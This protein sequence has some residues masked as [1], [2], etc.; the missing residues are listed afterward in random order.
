MQSSVMT[1]P[2]DAVPEARFNYDVSPMS[3]IVKKT[4]RRYVT[5]QSLS[6]RDNTL[7]K[8]MW[9]EAIVPPGSP[10]RILNRDLLVCSCRWYEF[11][12]S[13]CGIIGGTYQVMGLIDSALYRVTKGGKG[14]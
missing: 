13:V 1:Y 9:G 3:V 6:M 10:R 14:L 5:F 2:D 8:A 11:V 7:I 4:G 12:T